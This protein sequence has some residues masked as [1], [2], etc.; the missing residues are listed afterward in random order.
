MGMV[1]ALTEPDYLTAGPA[2]LFSP[3]WGTHA[4]LI[5]QHRRDLIDTLVPYLQS[6]FE[7]DACCVW[8]TA[9]PLQADAAQKVLARSVKDLDRR[10]KRGEIQ[11]LDARDW[12]L[13][14]G[15]F[16]CS[17]ALNNCIQKGIEAQKRGYE[18]LF[19]TGNISWL[20]GAEWDMFMEYE[21]V[22]NQVIGNSRIAAICAY[23]LSACGARELLEVAST[24]RAAAIRQDGIWREVALG[25]ETLPGEATRM[26]ISQIEANIEQFATLADRIRHPL[27]L[28]MATADLSENEYSE[29]IRQ[30]VQKIDAIV[31]QLDAG[32]AGSRAVREYLQNRDFTGGR[33]APVTGSGPFPHPSGYPDSRRSF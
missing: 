7:R 25:E 2:A 31:R 8:L 26:A 5:Y 9:R 20:T 27:Q 3:P 19:L 6:G 22:V 12:Y 30:Q 13:Q 24:H 23:P 4:C 28:L 1:P 32:W 14:D 21:T 16:S 15:R 11:I 18:G 17:A 33:T 10:L 29:V